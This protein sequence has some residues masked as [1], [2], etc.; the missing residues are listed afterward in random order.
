MIYNIAP[1]IHKDKEYTF[2][3]GGSGILDLVI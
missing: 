2:Y 1:K 3:T